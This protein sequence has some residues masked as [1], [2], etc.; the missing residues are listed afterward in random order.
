MSPASSEHPAFPDKNIFA[1]PPASFS[2]TQDLLQHIWQAIGFLHA[3]ISDITDHGV[4][5]KVR[6]DLYLPALSTDENPFLSLYPRINETDWDIQYENGIPILCNTSQNRERIDTLFAEVFPD[7]HSYHVLTN[8]S[9]PSPQAPLKIFAIISWEDIRR[10]GRTYLT[11][12]REPQIP[13]ITV[14]LY[15]KPADEGLSLREI[16]ELYL[17]LN[18]N[19]VIPV[20]VE[21]PNGTS[22][23]LGFAT[24]K[25]A[26][27]DDFTAPLQNV[28]NDM[29]KEN[30]HHLYAIQSADHPTYFAWMAR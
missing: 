4:Y 21:H 1:A 14:A 13:P 11:G 25:A 19:Q 8:A 2:L 16:E 9:N 10:L 12:I 24:K 29:K 3:E 15:E 7:R 27:S 26:E 28:L 6:R 23:A 30:E 18:T 5:V 17:L 20:T 22:V